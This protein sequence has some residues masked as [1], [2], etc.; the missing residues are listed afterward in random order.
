MASVLSLAVSD[1]LV[2]EAE[3]RRL[4][5]TALQVLRELPDATQVAGDALKHAV[6][7]EA[8]ELLPSSV[9]VFVRHNQRLVGGDAELPK[10]EAGQC[11]SLARPKDRSGNILRA[12]AVE[13]R[14]LV[15]VAGTARASYGVGTVL[16]ASLVAAVFAAAMA[17]I[18]R[19]HV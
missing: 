5:A 12:C 15:V 10:L 11:L 9:T 6:D 16:L 1:R 19:A 2:R 17:E 14:G 7:E 8:A 3:D 18:G 13:E 4:R